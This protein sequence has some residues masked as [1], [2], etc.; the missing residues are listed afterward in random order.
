MTLYA[1]LSN[2][3]IDPQPKPQPIPE[4]KRR[5]DERLKKSGRVAEKEL[6]A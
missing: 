1:R 2:P 4:W 5:M 6:V 3:K